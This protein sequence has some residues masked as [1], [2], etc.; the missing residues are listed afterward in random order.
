MNPIAK[1][2]DFHAI[3]HS[4]TGRILISIVWGLGLAAMF[5]RVCKDRSCIVYQSPNP[6]WMKQQILK[7]KKSNSCYQMTTELSECENK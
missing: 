5:R 1:G 4:H 6:D 2:F 7:T 3:F